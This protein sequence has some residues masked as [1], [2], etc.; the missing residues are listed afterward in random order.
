MLSVS[1]CFCRPNED[2]TL[3]AASVTGECELTDLGA[4]LGGNFG[5]V[6]ELQVL[7]GI[8]TYLQPHF[9]FKENL[10]SHPKPY[11]CVI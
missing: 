1:R 2:T 4:V 10:G 6:E 11:T 5:P 3:S 9:D 7:V 8:E